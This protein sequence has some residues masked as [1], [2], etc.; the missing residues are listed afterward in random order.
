MQSFAVAFIYLITLGWQKN[1]KNKSSASWNKDGFAFQHREKKQKQ[2]LVN[3]IRMMLDEVQKEKR[4]KLQPHG[5]LWRENESGV[6]LS[7]SQGVWGDS[8]W[9]SMIC[10]WVSRAICWLSQTAGDYNYPG[11]GGGDGPACGVGRTP[12]TPP[13]LGRGPQPAASLTAARLRLY[14]R[15]G[16]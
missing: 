8:C 15:R 7:E 5:K 9:V 10:Q 16:L 14:S 1:S 11:A 3:I 12:F 13:T 6:D 2:G 4:K